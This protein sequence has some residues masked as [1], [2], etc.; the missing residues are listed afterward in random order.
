[1]SVSTPTELLVLSSS[2]DKDG[3]FSVDGVTV[4]SMASLFEGPG[5]FSSSVVR[6]CP[7]SVSNFVEVDETLALAI[8]L[9]LTAVEENDVVAVAVDASESEV[10]GKELL[11]DE[12]VVDV[13]VIMTEGVDIAEAVSAK[14]GCLVSIF[15]VDRTEE[16]L[17]V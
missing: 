15:I 16:L 7:P 9:P 3:V 11:A 10:I 4:S 14:V 6:N 2:T 17:V 1:M 8:L 12:S 13:L 5:T